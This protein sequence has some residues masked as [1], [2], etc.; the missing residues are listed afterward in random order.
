MLP[1]P[2]ITCV[3]SCYVTFHLMF[4][5]LDLL[6]TILWVRSPFSRRTRKGETERSNF[7]AVSSTVT[8]SRG[9]DDVTTTCGDVQL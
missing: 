5:Y 6:Q 1:S 4:L 7:C 2:V 9:S 3:S 8:A